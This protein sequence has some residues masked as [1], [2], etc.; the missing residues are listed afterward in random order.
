MSKWLNRRLIE[1]DML[2]PF[3]RKSSHDHAYNALGVG[4]HLRDE[5]GRQCF[6]DEAF[7]H[8]Q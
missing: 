8:E 7:I 3:E 2:E 6:I 5:K 4:G 1:Y